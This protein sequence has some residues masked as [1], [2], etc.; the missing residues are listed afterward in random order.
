M[1]MNKNNSDNQ[2]KKLKVGLIGAGFMGK[3][4]SI[5]WHALPAVFPQ[6]V[7]II[8]EAISAVTPKETDKACAELDFKRGINDWRDLVNDPDIDIIDICSPNFLHKEMILAAIHAGKKAIY[9]E[10]PLSLN[11]QDS[12]E[13]ANLAQIHNV[14]SMTGFNYAKNPVCSLAKEIIQNGEI[15][16]IYHFR[17]THCEDYLLDARAHHSWRLV[18]ATGGSGAL[19]DLCHIIHMA[20]HLVD[21]IEAVC[22]NIQT[23]I[24]ERADLQGVMQIVENED[25][26]HALIKF[27]NG[28]I[29]TLEF[30]RVAAG[31]KMGLTYEIN[32]E[33][34]SIY[35][36]QS[37][38]SE[39]QLYTNTDASNRQG[40]R[41]IL[42]G[43]EHPD[44]GGFCVASGH[45]LG[46]NDMKVV[47]V[48][49]FVD[50]ILNQ[51][52]ARPDFR[53]AYKVDCIIAAIIESSNEKRWIELG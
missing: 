8:C 51:T 36:D 2:N 35:F 52:R 18:K 28:T 40:F 50:A 5:A 21:D 29:G 39:L 22:G 3:A 49:D 24:P 41:T 42:A 44:Y 32:G 6:G 23:V 15:G 17:G 31:R 10:K 20:M 43:P 33:L 11:P 13:I 26:A 53:D 30:S 14:I 27:K 19:G 25:Q 47:E 16:K 4:H 38:M 48:R 7:E 37:R 45:G 34:G 9:C 12:L 46:F 1:N